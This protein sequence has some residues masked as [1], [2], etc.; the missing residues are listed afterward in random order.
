MRVVDVVFY[1]KEKEVRGMFGGGV[2]EGDASVRP[3]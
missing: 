2:W 3:C 1:R